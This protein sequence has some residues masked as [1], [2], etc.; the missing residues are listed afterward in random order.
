MQ[1]YVSFDWARLAQFA[2]RRGSPSLEASDDWV[3]LEIAHALKRDITVIPVR[4]NGAELPQKPRCRM[5]FEGYL[6]I[7]PCQSP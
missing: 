6:I 7:R 5:T 2:G 1:G 4:V 3:R